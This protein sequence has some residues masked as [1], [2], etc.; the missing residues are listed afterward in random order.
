MLPD[1]NLSW[2]SDIDGPLGTGHQ[3]LLTHLSPGTHHL[4]LT[5]HDLSG[6]VASAAVTLVV[7]DRPNFQPMANAGPDWNASL[8][9][10]L[11]DAGASFDLD[12]EPLVYLW[13][14]ASQPPGSQAYLSSPESMRTFLIAS[15]PGTYIVQLI[16]HD[17]Q[18]ASQPDQVTITVS[19]AALGYCQFVPS[20]KR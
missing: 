10:P 15:Q 12:N 14:I 8:C 11:L 3:V 1:Q 18:I 20:L 13:S 4:V 2:T 7:E 16:V 5:G 19:G 17:G 9:S 6:A